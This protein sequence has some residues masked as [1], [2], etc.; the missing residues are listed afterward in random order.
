M[1]YAAV[2][3]VRK[4]S[5]RKAPVA[6]FAGLSAAGRGAAP[7]QGERRRGADVRGETGDAGTGD[8]SLLWERASI[9]FGLSVAQPPTADAA[10]RAE[11]L[12]PLSRTEDV[13][14][15]NEK[16]KIEHQAH[17]GGF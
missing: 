16:T 10:G 3:T 11:A 17:A 15:G 14:F 12:H 1:P 9:A 2:R 13:A 6:P 7:P 5:P 4:S 8:F